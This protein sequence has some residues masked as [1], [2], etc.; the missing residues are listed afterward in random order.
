MTQQDVI[1]VVSDTAQRRGL[2]PQLMVRVAEIESRL[3]PRAVNRSSGAAG[4][5]Q[6][7]PNLWQSYGLTATSVFDAA[8]N[9]DAAAKKMLTATRY[10]QERG[11]HVEPW[12]LY[13]AHQQGNYGAS[14]ILDAARRGLTISEL[15][16]SPA[17]IRRNVLANIPSSVSLTTVAAFVDF[18]RNKFGL[19]STAAVVPV[20]ATPTRSTQPQAAKKFSTTQWIAAGIVTSAALYAVGRTMKVTPRLWILP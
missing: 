17:N 13:L 19:P 5:F 11:I 10:L 3:N 7:L 4:L 1:K 20:A 12:M 15:P 8:A 16:T 14:V 18:W 9:A 6:F 2:D